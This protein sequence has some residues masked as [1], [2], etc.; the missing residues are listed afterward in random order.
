MAMIT[1][2]RNFTIALHNGGSYSSEWVRVPEGNQNWQ[3]VVLVHGRISTT[4]ASLTLNTTWDTSLQHSAGASVNLA[5]L[6]VN[7]QDITTDMG[8]M[9]RVSISST[10]DSVATISVFLTPKND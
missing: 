2:L 7:E 4:A 8:P 3:L 10:A 6:G 1:L 5:T 9:A